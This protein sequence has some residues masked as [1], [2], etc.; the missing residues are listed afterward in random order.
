MVRVGLAWLRSIAQVLQEL[1]KRIS[2]RRAPLLSVKRCGYMLTDGISSLVIDT[3]CDRVVD[4]GIAV[5]CFYCDF[6]SRKIQT[7]EN[8]LGALV[9]Q[10]VCGLGAIPAEIDAAF[11]KAKSQV[12][13]RGL[14]VPEALSLLRA[15]IAPLDRAFVCIDA[16]DELLGKNLPKLLRSLH[17]ISQSCPRLRFFFTGRPHVGAEITK[18][19]PGGAQ[20]LQ[21]KPTRKDIMRYVEM[22]LDEDPDP[23]AMNASLQAEIM[24]RVSETIS[25]VYV[26]A[27]FRSTLEALL[28]VVHR[29]LLVSLNITAILD[30]TTIYGRREQLKRMTN[31]RGLGDAYG[32]TLDR[33]RAQ[34]EG[35][36][37]LGMAAL[38]WVSRAERPM[39]PDELC[40]AL[41]VQIGSTDPNPNSQ[42]S[43]ASSPSVFS[44]GRDGRRILCPCPGR[45][46]NCSPS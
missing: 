38:M 41:G 28:I 43:Q 6:Q 14:R 19:F 4:Q 29:F 37:R 9:K 27:I 39:S 7:P 26:A 24:N 25:D 11:R 33:M 17:A 46:P 40:H 20:F 34:S 36:S 32:T 21:I 3:L 23:E 2:R 16:L 12:G 35:K 30:E 13:G 44:L 15:A 1:G 5:A 8:V 18:C 22:M 10:I 42:C 31:G 45:T